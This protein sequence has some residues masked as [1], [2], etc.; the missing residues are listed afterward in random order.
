MQ[1]ETIC[2]SIIDACKWLREQ[3]LI[4]GTWGNISVRYEKGF[5]ITPSRISYDEMTSADLVYMD[6]EGNITKGSCIPSSERHIHRLILKKR[7]DINAVVHTHSAC[8]CAASA[9]GID[10]EP[11]IEEIAQLVGGPIPCTPYY[12][13]GGNHLELGKLVVKTLGCVNSLLIRNH[14]AVC[15]GT[16]LNEALV[17]CQVTEKA[18]CIILK[19]IGSTKYNSIP[20]NF[21]M[22]ERKRFIEKYGKE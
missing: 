2:R 7:P 11:V 20:E 14:G 6:L 5:I 12:I 8:A 3:K 13:T 16:S 22:E 21:V 1:E 18:A 10:L 19:L 17:C 15:C 4:Y 9:A